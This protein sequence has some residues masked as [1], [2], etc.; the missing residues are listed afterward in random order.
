MQEG[1]DWQVVY[2]PLFKKT[3]PFKAPPY[4]LNRFGCLSLK[5]AILIPIRYFVTNT[6]WGYGYRIASV[7]AM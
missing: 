7:N 2:F 3:A 1:R 5:Q 6:I 4:H